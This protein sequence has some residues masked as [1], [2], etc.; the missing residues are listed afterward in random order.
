[1]SSIRT[2]PLPAASSFLSRIGVD[3]RILGADIP[4]ADALVAA[5]AAALLAVVEQTHASHLVDVETLCSYRVPLLGEGGSCSLF[6]QL[7]PAPY[8]L[9]AILGPA[10]PRLLSLLARAQSLVEAAHA[11]MGVDWVGWPWA[12]GGGAVPASTHFCF[13]L[14]FLLFFFFFSFLIPLYLLSSL[15]LCISLHL[16]QTLFIFN[17]SFSSRSLFLQLLPSFLPSLS[18]LSLCLSLPHTQGM[19]HLSAHYFIKKADTH[20]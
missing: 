13:S 15:N 8:D 1:M 9:R 4:T 3:T 18:P 7:A 20:K 16:A 2:Q 11:L 19:P 10:T 17:L 5:E 12:H 14:S 6:G